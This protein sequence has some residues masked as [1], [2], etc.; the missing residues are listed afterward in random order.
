L[1][2]EGS[3]FTCISRVETGELGR[4]ESKKKTQRRGVDK[5][6]KSEEERGKKPQKKREHGISLTEES[7]CGTEVQK[8]GD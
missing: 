6:E 7:G 2:F 3:M 5:H 1:N 4:K 8:G